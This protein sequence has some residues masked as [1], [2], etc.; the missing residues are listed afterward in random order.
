MAVFEGSG[1]VQLR[2]YDREYKGTTLQYRVRHED[3]M[4][5][6]SEWRDV[7][8]VSETNSDDQANR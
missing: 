4:Y 3:K 5:L 8:T 7:P 1:V 6:W 2:W